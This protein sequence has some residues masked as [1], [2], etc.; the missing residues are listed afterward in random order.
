MPR[1]GSAG[2]MQVRPPRFADR[3]DVVVA[4]HA[5]DLERFRLRPLGEDP[6]PER[7]AARPELA[8]HCFVHDR[9][10]VPALDIVGGE[11][12]AADNRNADRLEILIADRR[13]VDQ[14]LVVGRG[15]E[16]VHSNAAHVDVGRERQARRD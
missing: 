5:N 1:S 10:A 14:R 9:H 3:A 6:T 4:R 15:M 11:G 13:D 2:T 8:R 7:R 12:A 16:S